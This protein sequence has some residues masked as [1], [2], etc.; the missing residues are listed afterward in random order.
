MRKLC[1]NEIGG[2]K[3]KKNEKKTCFTIRK[4][5]FFS[6]CSFGFAF[7]RWLVKLEHNILNHSKWRRIEKDLPQ[8][9]MFA[10]KLV[11][12]AGPVYT[13]SISREVPKFR[14]PST[15]W[16]GHS[17]LS[18]FLI[19]HF[20]K[21]EKNGRSFR[22]GRSCYMAWGISNLEGPPIAGSSLIH[23]HPC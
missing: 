11:F 9:K 20:K 5:L 8:A 2:V 17:E 21:Q 13:T 19:C 22:R 15:A 7:Q 12:S 23:N 18:S 4:I 16:A 6:G 1:T 3:M 14:R 10:D